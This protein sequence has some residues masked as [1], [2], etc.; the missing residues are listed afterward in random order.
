MKVFLSHS[1]ASA[2]HG[3]RLGE[4]LAA[5]GIEP[6]GARSVVR[7]GEDWATAIEQQVKDADALVFLIEPEA[8][9]DALLQKQWQLAL[10][11]S[12]S[13][14][15]KPLIP[16]LL[17]D[18]ELPGFLKN[19]QAISVASEQDLGTVAQ[20]VASG[21]STG[22]RFAHL[23][24]AEESRAV[25]RKQRLEEITR[26]TTQLAPTDE[27][28]RRHATLLRK[29]IE[30]TGRSR[31][32]S[33]ELAEL[34]VELADV[35]KRLAQGAEALP[36]LEAADEILRKHPKAERRRARV[37]ANLGTLLWR[38]GR[39]DEARARL[40]SARDLYL[41]LEGPE[42]LITLLTRRSFA[43][44]LEELGDVDAA[45]REREEVNLGA[46]KLAIRIADRIDPRLGRA[47]DRLLHGKRE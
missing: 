36:E 46:K 27:E 7:P 6:V 41:E 32:D 21:L 12:W 23:P 29:R 28:L 44:L 26:D 39:K 20:L 19:R 38:L 30:E 33:V 31:P 42:A 4:L 13:A 45:G 47:V 3:A 15:D 16:V 8:R 43:K 5:E 40:E 35:L 17:G 10:Q 9:G 14:P 18:A 25:E 1:D 11:E 22:E 37:L 2:T 24:A 34:H